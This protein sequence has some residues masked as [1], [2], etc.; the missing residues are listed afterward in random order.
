[1][2]GTSVPS[3]ATPA[4]TFSS[5]MNQEEKQAAAMPSDF[6]LGGSKGFDEPPF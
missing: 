4:V 1:M 5:R 3:A 6:P 2:L